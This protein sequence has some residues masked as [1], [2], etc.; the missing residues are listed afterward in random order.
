M[1]NTCRSLECSICCDKTE[2]T[3]NMTIRCTHKPSICQD[4]IN[5]YVNIQLNQRNTLIKCLIDECDS[6]M[7]YQDVQRVVSQEN[8]Q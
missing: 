2:N 6:V 3:L 5:K 8:F 4:C 7:E 1:T